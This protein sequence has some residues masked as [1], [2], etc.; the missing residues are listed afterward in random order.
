MRVFRNYVAFYKLT[1]SEIIIVRVS[2]GARDQASLF[3]QE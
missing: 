3:R 2:H 1:A